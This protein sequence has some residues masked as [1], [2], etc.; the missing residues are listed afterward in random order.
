M[1]F[2]HARVGDLDDIEA[3]LGE[4]VQ[5]DACV[6]LDVRSLPE[7]EHADVDPALSQGPRDDE[8]VAP[9]VAPAGQHRHAHR[10]ELVERGF[11]RADDLAPRVLHQH[12]RRDADVL[13]RAA[14]GLLHLLTG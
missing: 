1:Q 5:V 2:P 7:E 14:I 12:H 13:D 8:A 3:E 11:D 10:V 4:D 6:T 9:V